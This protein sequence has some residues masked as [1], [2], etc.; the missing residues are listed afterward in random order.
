LCCAS[1]RRDGF[2]AHDG[3]FEVL[4]AGFVQRDVAEG[5]I[6]QFETGVEPHVEGFD[7]FV[8]F[9]P[10][11][12]LAFIYEAHHRD[13]LLPQGGEQFRGHFR[14]GRGGHRIRGASRQIVN[15]DGDLAIW[16]SSGPGIR[17]SPNHAEGKH[18]EQASQQRLHESSPPA[19]H[20]S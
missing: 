12:E 7:A 6:S 15:G 20:V 1:K 18:S 8:D 4:E 5:V 10:F 9:T 11:V 3:F 17:G 19:R 14:D 16:W 2:S 13:L